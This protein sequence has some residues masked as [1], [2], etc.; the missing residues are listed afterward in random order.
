MLNYQ[1]VKVQILESNLTRHAFFFNLL[2]YPLDAHS[3]LAHH[4][5]ATCWEIQPAY[6]P[7]SI[8]IFN[9]TNSMRNISKL[10]MKWSDANIKHI[11]K[12]KD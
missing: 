10:A 6:H 4:R 5:A 8:S 1:V 9:Q 11:L 3:E 2:D 12:I 7:L